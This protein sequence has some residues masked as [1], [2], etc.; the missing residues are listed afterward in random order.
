MAQNASATLGEQSY[1]HP[2][3]VY[4]IYIGYSAQSV[5]VGVVS[6]DFN[7]PRTRMIGPSVAHLNH[8]ACSRHSP[9]CV[10]ASRRLVRWQ[11][12]AHLHAVK[13][14]SPPELQR[15]KLTRCTDARRRPG[16]AVKLLCVDAGCR[17]E[18][19]R[20]TIDHAK[21]DAALWSQGGRSYNVRILGVGGHSLR[22][23]SRDASF[24][25]RLSDHVQVLQEGC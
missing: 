24:L 14:R 5:S 6:S 11:W 17:G 13:G 22:E 3:A 16:R 18:I 25:S 2:T 10:D 4:D 21:P 15:D 12:Y 19:R 9:R 23:R 20:R 8:E 1:A 7:H